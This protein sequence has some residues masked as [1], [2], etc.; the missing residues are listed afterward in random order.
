MRILNVVGARPNLMKMAPIVAEMARQPAIEQRLLHTGQHY[1]EN[2]SEVFF[3]EL[4][5]PQPDIYLGVGSG[6]HA[7]QTAQIMIAFEKICQ[8]YRP[9]LVVLVPSSGC[10]WPTSKPGFA[11]LTVACQRRSTA[12]SPT[13]SLT[14]C[15]RHR[16]TA[17]RTCFTKGSRLPASIS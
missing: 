9:E 16:A 4:G 17:G 15:S 5:L 8:D 2:M 12:S 14:C 11:A 10:R 13:P 1:D 6:S 3:R 7:W